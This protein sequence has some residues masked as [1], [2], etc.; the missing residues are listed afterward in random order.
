MFLSVVLFLI[1]G[2]LA[3]TFT[4]LFPGIH[5]NLISSLIL[6]FPKSDLF[7]VFIISMAITHTF[8]DVIPSAYLGIPSDVLFASLPLHRFTLEGKSLKGIYYTLYGSLF[9]VFFSFLIIIPVYMLIENFY[10]TISKIFPF[11]IFII[12]INLFM[13]KKKLSKLAFLFSFLFGFITLNQ[14]NLI[15]PLF[16]MLSGMFGIATLNFS[17][18]SIPKQKKIVIPPKIK[19]FFYSFFASIGGLLT[20]LA[21]GIG[22]AF[23]MLFLSKMTTF[24]EEK[25][26]VVTGGINTS[27]FFFSVIT[28]FLYDKSR[29]G[30]IS[31][32]SEFFKPNFLTV[33]AFYIIILIASCTAFIIGQK[34]SILFSKT[35]SKLNIKVVN[36]ILIGFILTISF[37]FDG[38]L[39]LL[40]IFCSTLIGKFVLSNNISR[41]IP[42]ISILGPTLINIV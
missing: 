40:V 39:G 7:A 37:S 20:S 42:L 28:F 13:I 18:S 21:P 4:G 9:T 25:Y 41:K 17:N 15:N 22:S 16:H 5:V 8:L 38:F 24:S 19:Y 33:V 34:I 23:A 27:N 36:I 35:I 2:I 32:I 3:G 30:A 26:L 14:L 11:L 29:N 12:L 1:L 10:E 31:A 6:L